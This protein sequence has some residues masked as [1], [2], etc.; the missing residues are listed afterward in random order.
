[1]IAVSMR[2]CIY[3]QADILDVNQIFRD[4][5]L[6]VHEQGEVIGNY[7]FSAIS[8]FLHFSRS[9]CMQWLFSQS[10]S[11]FARDSIYAIA[12][13][14]YRPSVCPSIHLSHGWISQKRLKLGS[15]NF[16]HQV[17]H[18]SSFLTVNFTPKFQGELRERV[19][20]IREGYEKYAI[21]SQ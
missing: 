18:D 9:Y 13:I 12:R 10:M 14:C 21:F 15:C 1:M 3:F 6:M 8:V 20:Q 17:P 4:L 16:H 2:C 19:R 11:I 5:G 7:L